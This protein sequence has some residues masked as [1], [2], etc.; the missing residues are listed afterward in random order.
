MI[1][2]MP[3]VVCWVCAWI[4]CVC[5]H[6]WARLHVHGCTE[7]VCMLLLPTRVCIWGSFFLFWC[8]FCESLCSSTYLHVLLLRTY[9]RMALQRPWE[10]Y[11]QIIFK[12]PGK[13]W[14][15]TLAVLA[16][17]RQRKEDGYMSR[18][19]SGAQ[20]NLVTN[21]NSKMWNMPVIMGLGRL[22]KEFI[23]SLRQLWAAWWTPD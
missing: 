5:A 17:G 3:Q 21:I 9:F 2:F 1:T 13:V 23:M 15:P 18:T 11:I 4:I 7:S 20:Q 16:L 10:N 12:L 6:V 8:L 14:W 19:A 22:I